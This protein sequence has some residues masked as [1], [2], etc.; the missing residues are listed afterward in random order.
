MS[1]PLVVAFAHR[2][3]R[4][5]STSTREPLGER[6]TG[7]TSS[8]ATSGRRMQEVDALLASAFDPDEYRR[9]YADFA[10]AESRSGT[11]SRSRRGSSTSGIRARPTSASRPT[12]S[13]SMAADAVAG[14][15]RRARARDL[16]RLDHDRPHQP[17]RRDQ[18]DLAGR[19]VP[20]RARRR[21][22]GLQQLR[23]APRQ[24]RG[25]GARHV[26]QRPHPEPHGARRRGRRHPPPAERRAHGDLRRGRALPRR[27]RAA[28]RDRRTRL[29]RR[30]LARLGRQGH[31][32]ARACAPSSR[33]AS[34][35]SI[36]RT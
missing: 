34:S 3:P 14:H 33:A 9:V 18:A 29:R 25:H 22:R 16:R 5:T 26:R 31:A 19:H 35:G 36:A 28:H 17:G 32:P 1:P 13:A 30:Q 6:S 10:R 23:R 8:C 4:S 24:P 20:A 11:R 27:G 21:R 15:P 7:A 2:R 12:S